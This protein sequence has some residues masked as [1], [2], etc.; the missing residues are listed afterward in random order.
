[1]T[2]QIENNYQ[3]KRPSRPKSRRKSYQTIR[4]KKTVLKINAL[5]NTL[6]VPTQ[7]A[8]VDQTIERVVKFIECR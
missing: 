1:M 4:L 3:Q 2:K 5:V 7:D 6:G 8:I